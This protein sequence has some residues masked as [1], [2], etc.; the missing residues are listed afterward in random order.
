MATS[1]AASSTR[2]LTQAHVLTAKIVRWLLLTVV[3]LYLASGLGITEFRTVEPLTF[4]LLTKAV[5]FRLHDALLVPFIALLAL[6][7]T[8]GPFV[9][10]LRRL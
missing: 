3:L 5:G 1:T 4:G 8:L 2:R 7:V 6:H 10:L 9:R